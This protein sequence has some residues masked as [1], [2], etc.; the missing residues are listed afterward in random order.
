MFADINVIDIG[1]TD[2]E[3]KRDAHHA[4][5]KLAAL[6]YHSGT[7][8]IRSSMGKKK[9]AVLMGWLPNYSYPASQ[10]LISSESSHSEKRNSK[11]NRA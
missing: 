2:I 6:Q 8:L 3:R 9:L 1:H 11:E 4:K 7:M 5:T 10:G